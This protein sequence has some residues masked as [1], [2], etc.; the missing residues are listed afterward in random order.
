MS[1]GM[2][3]TPSSSPAMATGFSRRTIAL[4]VA[5]AISLA[6]CVFLM[7]GASGG[8]IAHAQTTTVTAKGLTDHE[9]DSTEWHFVITGIRNG[10]SAPGSIRVTWANGAVLDVPLDRV[11]GQVAH[12]ETTANLGS[13]VVSATAVLPV[14]WSGQFNLSHGPCGPTTPPTTTTAPPPS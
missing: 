9:C 14:G 11:T 7:G 4:L 3:F 6:V 12:Y 5:A 2:N 10:I 13:T 8:N 1:E